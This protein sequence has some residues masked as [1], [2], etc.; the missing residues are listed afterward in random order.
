MVEIMVVISIAGTLMAMSVWGIRGW[1][2]SSAFKGAP[3][4]IQAV[5]RAT[6]QQAITEGTPYCVT[7][8]TVADQYS[9]YRHECTDPTKV[10]TKGPFGTGS[11]QVK[12]FEPVFTDASGAPHTG[13]TFLPRGSAWAGQVVLT[14]GS[15]MTHEVHVEGMTGRVWTK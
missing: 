7:F 2:Q 15:S 14:R 13:V 4:Q 12:L 9:V 3:Q 1:A 8:D 10:K 6:Q 5:L 11:S